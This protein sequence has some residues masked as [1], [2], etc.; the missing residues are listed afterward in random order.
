M[1]VNLQLSRLEGAILFI[2]LITYVVLTIHLAR[3]GGEQQLTN[4]IT[5]HL[6]ACSGSIG[7][8]LLWL[9][10]GIA[11]LVAGANLLVLGAVNLARDAGISEA[12]IALTLIAGGTGLPELATSIV[13]ALKKESDLAVGNIIGSNIF[14]LLCIGGLTA[15]VK[16][17]I[18]PDIAPTDLLT[19]G[20]LTVLLLPTCWTGLRF[21][22]REATLFLAAYG[23]YLYLLWPHAT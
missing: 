18:S 19:M 20:I 8:D 3:R 1:V 4:E 9:A 13:A 11:L 22:R 7:R 10:G 14:N 5:D 21:G 2:G 17:V 16:P 12:V 23:V 15:L 6:P